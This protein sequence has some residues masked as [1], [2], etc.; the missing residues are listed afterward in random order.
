MLL[1][2]ELIEV[3]EL[4][5][6]QDIVSIK[7]IPLGVYNEPNLFYHYKT[8]NQRESPKPLVGK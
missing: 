8:T 7:E 5:H 6:N 1:T 3:M 4:D 2:G